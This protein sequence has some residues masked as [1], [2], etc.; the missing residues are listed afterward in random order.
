MTMLI[1][2]AFRRV[3]SF[4]ERKSMFTNLI[5]LSLTVLV[6]ATALAQAQRKH[7]P[8]NNQTPLT[9]KQIAKRVLPSVVLVET[10]CGRGR[11]MVG[12]GFFVDK[13]LVA[14]NKHVVECGNEGYV[15][16]VG[17]GTKHRVIAK[18]LDSVHDL[19]LLKAEGLNA[20]AL[21]LSDAQNLSIGDTVYV[22]GNPRELEGTFSNG[23]ISSLRYSAGVIQ[24]TAPISPGS[25][26]GPVVDEMGRVIGLTVSSVTSGQNLNFAVPTYFLLRLIADMR[27][28]KVN[29]AL[30]AK[31]SPPPQP[32][33]AR[34]AG[35]LSYT[36]IIDNSSTLGEQ[37]V[38]VKRVAHALIEHNDMDDGTRIISFRPNGERRSARFTT[39]R[40][41]LLESVTAIE[42]RSDGWTQPV[43]DTMQDAIQSAAYP[44]RNFDTDAVIVL[45]HGMDGVSEATWE[46]LHSLARERKVPVYCVLFAPEMPDLSRYDTDRQLKEIERWRART[47]SSEE[48]LRVIT[49]ESGGKLL[50]PKS[51]DQLEGFAS[52]IMRDLRAA[53]KN[54]ALP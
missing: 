23:I 7:P 32:T 51:E 45:T 29:D 11:L 33:P 15:T 46:Q 8:Q 21:P 24:F 52:E 36:L 49:Q 39:D 40:R 48:W 41:A 1:R 16:L 4:S 19:A 54:A 13:G 53:R 12:S 27:S 42:A 22:A 18:Y 2:Y 37:F 6:L 30:T 31:S 34:R 17:Q 44:T 9:A 3:S 35:A 26:G 25:S 50:I 20:P 47:K 43:I 5:R 38:F 14:T 28:G 10:S